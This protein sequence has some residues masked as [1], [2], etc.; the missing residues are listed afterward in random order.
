MKL[1]KAL[2][3]IKNMKPSQYTD[4]QL[5]SWL[6]ELDGQVWQELLKKY[7]VPEPPLPYRDRA[8]SLEMAVPFPYDG[9][10]LTY[11]GA[12]IDYMNS[13]F[14]RYNNEMM[15][16]NAQLQTFYDAFTRNHMPE[17]VTHVTGV[18]AL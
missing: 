1:Y 16:F 17:K 13:E 2:E 5:V 4:E 11:L 14:E 9:L 8:L 12:K 6:S 3:Q 15:L 18:K 10:Y 7:G